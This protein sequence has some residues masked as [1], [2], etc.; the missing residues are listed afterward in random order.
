L[1]SSEYAI[2]TKTC[3]NEEQNYRI[4]EKEFNIAAEQLMFL[5]ILD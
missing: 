4:N 2:A 5:E 3:N 1:A